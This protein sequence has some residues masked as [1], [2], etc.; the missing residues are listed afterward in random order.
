MRRGQYYNKNEPMQQVACLIT[1]EKLQ[2][3]EQETPLSRKIEFYHFMCK[4]YR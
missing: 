1:T 3:K 2:V 4:T